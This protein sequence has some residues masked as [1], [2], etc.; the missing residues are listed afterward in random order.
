LEITLLVS[1]EEQV[2]IIN[3]QIRAVTSI[4]DGPAISSRM[5]DPSDQS[6]RSRDGNERNDR[7]T[8]QSARK[9]GITKEGRKT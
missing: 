6:V 8:G 4:S 7:L 9:T 3:E 1:G 5:P 2:R